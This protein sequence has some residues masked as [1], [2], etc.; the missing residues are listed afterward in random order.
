MGWGA[1]GRWGSLSGDPICPP[2]EEAPRDWEVMEQEMSGDET[3][4][5]CPHW[6]R[7]LVEMPVCGWATVAGLMV[8]HGTT[9]MGIRP[10]KVRLGKSEWRGQ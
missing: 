10:K 1:A 8:P 3:M 7:P 4:A 6:S 5:V 2:R 9:C